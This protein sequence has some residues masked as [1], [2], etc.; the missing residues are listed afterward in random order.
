MS[1]GLH[2]GVPYLEL[3][4]DHI[5]AHADGLGRRLGWVGCIGGIFFA[6]CRLSLA[7][8]AYTL[9]HFS[10]QRKRFLWDRECVYGLLRRCKE[11]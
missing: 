8:G 4:H 2:L 7:S 5:L 1:W 9:V 6:V 3:H 10:A 11:V